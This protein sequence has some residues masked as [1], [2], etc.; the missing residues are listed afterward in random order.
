MLFRSVGG[1]S[2]K[3]FNG[4]PMAVRSD[5]TSVPEMTA[6]EAVALVQ[7]LGVGEVLLNSVDRDGSLS[8]YDQEAFGEVLKE[9][10]VPTVLAGGAGNWGHLL[11]GIRSA[12]VAG[13]A[14]S[15]I[16]H[17]TSGAILAAK[18]FL[19]ENGVPVRSVQQEPEDYFL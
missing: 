19:A 3:R 18:A 14:T 12:G 1:I 13:V 15:N 7:E 6:R 5:R 8:G 17:L 4:E 9:I 2:L 11:W 10:S 16:Y